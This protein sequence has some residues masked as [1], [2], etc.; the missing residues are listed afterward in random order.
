MNIIDQYTMPVNVNNDCCRADSTLKKYQRMPIG[1]RTASFN[2]VLYEILKA[3]R[4]S[5][6]GLSLLI[7]P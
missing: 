5:N 2:F 4:K 7:H 3:C 1:S 6:S